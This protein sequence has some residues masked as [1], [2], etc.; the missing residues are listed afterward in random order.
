MKTQY[1]LDQIWNLEKPQLAKTL[2]HDVINHHHLLQNKKIALLVTGSIAA[3]KTPNLAR[4]LRKMG[5]EVWVYLSDKAKQ[6]VAIEAL[7]WCSGGNTVIS[8]LSSKAEH[9]SDRHPFDLYL[10]APASYQTINQFANGSA[11]NP[12]LTSLA[13]ALG[14]LEK[15]ETQILICPAMNADMYNQICQSNLLKLQNMGVHILEPRWN[16]ENK[17]HLPD[18]ERICAMTVRLLLSSHSHLK[19]KKV[20]V[21]A[22]AIPVYL[23]GVRLITNPFSGKLGIE[24]AK[25]LLYMGASVELLLGA[26]AVEAPEYIKHT[27]V[28]DLNEYQQWVD[29]LSQWADIGIYSAGVADFA[30]LTVLNGKTSSDLKQWDISLYPTPKIISLLRQKYPHQYMVTFK[31]MEQISLTDLFEIGYQRLDQYDMLVVNRGEEKE[32]G[33]QVAYIMTQEHKQNRAF[34]PQKS[35]NKFQ[36]AYEIVQ[37]IN[38]VY[39]S[40]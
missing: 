27:R 22:G 26:A 28:K 14:R 3:Y 40:K 10:I 37:N 7:S 36:I 38:Q 32:K 18:E 23:D 29:D 25:H 20:L 35:V 30:P 2:D 1:P 16:E 6:F 11:A 19:N 34:I 31:Y 13:V 17:L 21:T 9:L 39:Q 12:I 24:I 5:A 4:E 15:Q 33:E 8:D